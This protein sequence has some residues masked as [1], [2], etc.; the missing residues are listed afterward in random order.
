MTNGGV[1]NAVLLDVRR[2]AAPCRVICTCECRS[3]S[4]LGGYGR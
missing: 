2:G 1:R 3:R 4:G